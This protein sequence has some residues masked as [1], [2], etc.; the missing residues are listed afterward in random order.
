MSRILRSVSV[1]ALVLVLYLPCAPMT[2][3]V[4]AEREGAENVAVQQQDPD[5]LFGRTGGSI[6][7]R[8]QWHVARADS[9][10]FDFTSE[11]LTLEK[12]DF[13]APGIGVD[14]GFPIAP[15]LDVLVGLEFSRATA[16]SEYRDFVDTNDLPIEQ[17]TSLRQFNLSGS[18]ELAVLRRG[19][20]ISR[21]AW[22]P[23][24]V[25]PYVG[26]GGGFLWHRFEQEGD[27][28]DVFDCPV[29]FGCA[30]FT[31]HLTS[32]S[33]TPSGHVF[34]GVDFKLTPRVYLSTEIRYLWAQA[35]MSRDFIGFDDIDLTGLRVTGGVQVLF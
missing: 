19:R 16:G 4:A 3:A 31:E 2:S 17:T 23:A 33:W 9:E 32:S 29:D 13:N 5:F 10:I 8:G 35:E 27:F 7:V 34:G 6:G 21:Y 11:L 15:R 12:S 28:V 22:V 14:V 1:A 26:A 25:V 18:I 30:I 24:A 20:E